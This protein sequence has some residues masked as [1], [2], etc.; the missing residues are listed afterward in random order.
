MTDE[1]IEAR[2]KQYADYVKRQTDLREPILSYGKWKI[3]VTEIE[4]FNAE[5]ESS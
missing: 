3:V 1:A 4:R 5:S 2:R